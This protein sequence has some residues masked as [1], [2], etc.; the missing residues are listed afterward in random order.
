[1]LRSGVGAV[2]GPRV[3]G[4]GG[5]AGLA[6]D[7]VAG[8]HS[9]R[10]QDVRYSIVMVRTTSLRQSASSHLD[11]ER[12]D[13]LDGVAPDQGGVV[14]HPQQVEQV[15]ATV[16]EAGPEDEHLRLLDGAGTAVLDVVDVVDL[17]AELIFLLVPVGLEFV[18]TLAPR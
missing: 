9:L 17:L 2:V 11:V 5:G 1:M 16:V 6:H 12:V 14:V 13:V 4:G 3:A 7:V 10:R 15:V 18:L 8:A